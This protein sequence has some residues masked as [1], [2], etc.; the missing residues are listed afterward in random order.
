M[1]DKTDFYPLGKTYYFNFNDYSCHKCLTGKCP[2][3]ELT[4]EEIEK[5]PKPEGAYIKE[6]SWE[7]CA[8]LARKLLTYEDSPTIWMNFNKECGHYSFSDGQHRT[9]I[10]AR[11]YQKGKKIKFQPFLSGNQCKCPQ[12]DN[13]EYY[14]E[15]EKNLKLRDKIFKTEQYKR[16]L[17]FKNRKFKNCLYKFEET[18]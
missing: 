17:V 9:C 2:L 18:T 10:I 14:A 3:D 1:T 11:L 8:N 6:Q 16:V 4:I 15:I 7:Y 5:L 13:I 12:C